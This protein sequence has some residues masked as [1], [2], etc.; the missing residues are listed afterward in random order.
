MS[1]TATTASAAELNR[2]VVGENGLGLRQKTLLYIFCLSFAFDFKGPFGGTIFQYI[3]TVVA[4]G[5]GCLLWFQSF[6]KTAPHYTRLMMITLGSIFLLGYGTIIMN[7]YFEF[8]NIPLVRSLRFMFPYAMLVVSA[9]VMSSFAKNGTKLSVIV[10][11]MI[12]AAVLSMVWRQIYASVVVDVQ[13][14]EQ[15]YQAL[16]PALIFLIPMVMCFI[17]LRSKQNVFYWILLGASLITIFLSITR[18]FLF[19]IFIA[20]I[21]I[22]ICLF[23][24]G[25]LFQPALIIKRAVIGVLGLLAFSLALI[26]TMEIRPN[27]VANWEKRLSVTSDLQD[28]TRVA[29]VSR[30]LRVAAATGMVNA[31]KKEPYTIMLGKGFGAGYYLDRKYEGIIRTQIP[32]DAREQWHVVDVGLVYIFFAG[33][34]VIGGLILGIFLATLYLMIKAMYR[35]KKLGIKQEGFV[36]AAVSFVGVLFA[37]SQMP[38]SYVFQERMSAQTVGI[39]IGVGMV[40]ADRVNHLVRVQK[41][42][43]IRSNVRFDGVSEAAPA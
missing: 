34:I 37:L 28:A 2:F 43:R 30:I 22:T 13:L 38:S 23:L 5:S 7:N 26:I 40:V 24:Q 41:R 1:A 18:I 15:R 39:L 32:F 12:T 36:W 17:A 8:S 16:S 25:R 6:G 10:P 4:L 9:G 42:E 19:S 33:G 11:P 20:A 3:F 35:M 21:G 29:D 31:V 27:V 14:E